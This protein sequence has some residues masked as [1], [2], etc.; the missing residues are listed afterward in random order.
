MFEPLPEKPPYMAGRF[1]FMFGVAGGL[2]AVV[3]VG[4]LFGTERI[5]T[6]NAWLVCSFILGVGPGLWVGW[7]VLMPAPP[8]KLRDVTAPPS[9]PVVLP[10]LSS[11][12]LLEIEERLHASL[13]IAVAAVASAIAWAFFSGTDGPRWVATALALFQLGAYIWFAICVGEAAA[14][15]GETKWAYVTWVLAAPVLA[16]VPVPILSTVIGVSPLSLKFLLSGQLERRI[17]ERTFED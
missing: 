5:A 9:A 15:V 13:W 7:H 3:F 6:S 14:A 2:A 4:R 11:Q 1:L 12:Q 8:P 10:R 17:R 16:L